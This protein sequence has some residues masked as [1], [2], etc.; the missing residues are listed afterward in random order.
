MWLWDDPVNGVE[1]EVKL[2]LVTLHV[3]QLVSIHLICRNTIAICYF[4]PYPAA[5]VLIFVT[6]TILNY[7]TW[8]NKTTSCKLD[9]IQFYKSTNNGPHLSRWYDDIYL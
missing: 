4:C 5:L 7:L 8:A 2:S 1:T 9:D 6:F 3:H